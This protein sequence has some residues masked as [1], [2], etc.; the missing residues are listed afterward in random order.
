MASDGSL[1]ARNASIIGD[2]Q[3]IGDDVTEFAQLKDGNLTLGQNSRIDALIS[4]S[5]VGFGTMMSSGYKMDSVVPRIVVTVGEINGY[6]VHLKGSQ[7]GR[8]VA[9]VTTSPNIDT[10][11]RVIGSITIPIEGTYVVTGIIHASTAVNLQ[12]GVGVSSSTSSS[13]LASLITQRSDNTDWLTVT[14]V[15]NITSGGTTVYLVGRANGNATAASGTLIEYV[16]VN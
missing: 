14:R 4:R 8:K 1:C 10:T 7:M 3:S 6:A 13:A 9:T 11:V 5:P 2:I 15:I 16:K 12:A